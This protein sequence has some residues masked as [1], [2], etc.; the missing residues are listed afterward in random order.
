M[1]DWTS[2][3]TRPEMA[4]G[5]QY[6]IRCKRGDVERYVLLPG[7]PDR[8]DLI[9]AEW[10]ESRRIANYREHR[11]FSGRFD[12]VPITCCSTGAG[13]GSAANAV[14]ELANLGADTF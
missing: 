11:T 10:N 8:V 5:L 9:A 3:A 12:G 13:S 2:A 6:H 7:D 14:E 1:T 4:A